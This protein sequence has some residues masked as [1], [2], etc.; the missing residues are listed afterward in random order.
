MSKLIWKS[1]YT[2]KGERKSLITTALQ[3][4]DILTLR[5][6]WLNEKLRLP[7]LCEQ[8]KAV[9]IRDRTIALVTLATEVIER[10]RGEKNR[11]GLL[12]YDDLIA[13]T[14]DLLNSVDAAWVHYKLDLGID[15]L[16]IDEAQDT[17]PEQWDIIKR[18]VEEFTAGAGARSDIKRTIFAV[19]DDKQSIF[20]FQGAEPR[21]FDETRRFLPR[22]A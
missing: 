1:S 21:A 9:M 4:P 14:R 8:R 10:Y 19:G 2:D 6:A 11:R 12:D 15:H 7:S 3:Q 20:S 13:R 17:S 18:F 5:D 16:L 22:P